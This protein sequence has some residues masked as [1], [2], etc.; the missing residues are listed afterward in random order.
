MKPEAVMHLLTSDA[1]VSRAC[2]PRENHAFAK[3]D[4]RT[5]D[6]NGQR[7]FDGVRSEGDVL[8]ARAFVRSFVAAKGDERLAMLTREPVK[9]LVLSE[10]GRRPRSIG[11]PTYY[12]RCLSNLI[13]AALVRTCDARLSYIA[14]A[15]RP[16][17][18]K[19]V[20]TSIHEVAKKVTEGYHFWAKLDFRSFFSAL[21]WKAVGR[22]LRALG[23]PEDFVAL[24]GALL[25]TPVVEVRGR[26]HVRQVKWRGTEQGLAESTVI[27]NIVAHGLDT[28]LEG[29]RTVFVR[30]YSDDVII[31]GRRKA[32]V[33]RAIEVI[34]RWA[35]GLGIKVKD[36]RPGLKE[37]GVVSPGMSPRKLVTDV[38]EHGIT[39]LGAEIDAEGVIRP[40]PS[41]LHR[42]V[43]SLAGVMA[44]VVVGE[45]TGTS[46]YGDGRG[47]DAYDV[48]DYEAKRDGLR[49]YWL[50][51]GGETALEVV[52]SALRELV[53]SSPDSIVSEGETIW[54]ARLWASQTGSGKR[55]TSIRQGTSTPSAHHRPE[56]QAAFG[57]REEGRDR[58][59]ESIAKP[60]A[61]TGQGGSGYVTDG[62]YGQVEDRNE[63][64]EQRSAIPKL[65][66][67][68]ASGHGGE[69]GQADAWCLPST[70]TEEAGIHL[71]TGAEEAN[72]TDD[73][74]SSYPEG[75]TQ[76]STKESPSRSSDRE[77][78]TG[79]GTLWAV[80]G[81]SQAGIPDRFSVADP[82]SP[83]DQH[84]A[85]GESRSS[86]S[87]FREV[88]VGLRALGE[89][90]L[91]LV[92]GVREQHRVRLV[93]RRRARL[94]PEVEVLL[95]CI[96]LVHEHPVGDLIIHL[97]DSGLPKA[98]LQPGRAF[99]A[100]HYFGLVLDLH[101]AARAR[102]GS[103]VLVGGSRS[104]TSEIDLTP[105]DLVA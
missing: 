66:P 55:S 18:W 33:V 57:G 1:E 79:M 95:E 9:R 97:P 84:G 23:Y 45:V 35:D 77:V 56:P 62:T 63:R 47:L 48:E 52:E 4:A 96:R 91:L 37:A 16:G 61:R 103:V 83:R 94:R 80:N 42:K 43:E 67:R 78:E 24:V 15:Y 19:G 38:R 41:R 27:A 28:E 73:T 26:R 46:L 76:A 82:G 5:K 11:I 40:S 20:E 92:V 60:E 34:L 105:A 87:S 81:T 39:F 54:Q 69:I 21:P 32:D 99:R 101:Q 50:S 3:A 88:Y 7:L 6:A 25:R 68:P 89:V 30:R 13:T 8:A 71:T 86:S 93:R 98:L 2:D 74:F 12:R 102:C 58:A 104:G 51:L 65:K 14:C 64:E 36:E 70:G 10:E 72:G 17:R 75:N 90:G 53:R 29:L 31:L 100:P 44:K 22:G 85:L 49:R 59:S